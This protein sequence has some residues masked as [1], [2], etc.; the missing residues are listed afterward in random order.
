MSGRRL[1]GKKP[2]HQPRLQILIVPSSTKSEKRQNSNDNHDK[3]N[4]IDDTIH[5]GFL[6][7]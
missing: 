7:I 5:D 2:Q 3:S 4:D 1:R 6:S